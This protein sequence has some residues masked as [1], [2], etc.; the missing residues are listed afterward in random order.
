M[1]MTEGRETQ[2]SVIFLNLKTIYYWE[3]SVFWKGTLNNQ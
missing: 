2:P 3:F 1:F